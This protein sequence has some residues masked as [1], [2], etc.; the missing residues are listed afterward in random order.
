MQDNCDNTFS[1]GTTDL[2]IN[3]K[4]IVGPCSENMGYS[5]IL[6]YE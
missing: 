4:K 2:E 3:S 5:I 1:K 6:D